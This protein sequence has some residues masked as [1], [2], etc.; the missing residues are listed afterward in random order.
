MGVDSI[1]TN[2]ITNMNRK[3]KKEAHKLGLKITEYEG[4]IRGGLWDGEMM[5]RGL[6]VFET[7]P[8]HETCEETMTVCEFNLREVLTSMSENAECFAR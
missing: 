7:S 8:L 5:H 6:W 2:Q 1:T 3:I 4:F